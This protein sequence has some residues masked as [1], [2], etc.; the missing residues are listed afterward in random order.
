MSETNITLFDKIN[1]KDPLMKKW[2]A[3]GAAVIVSLIGMMQII[4][5]ALNIGDFGMGYDYIWTEYVMF[6]VQMIGSASS[7]YGVVYV[8]TKQRK[9]IY[10][11]TLGMTLFMI[12]GIVSGMLLEAIKRVF[13]IILNF[14]ILYNWSK[15]DKVPPIKRASNKEWYTFIP[16]VLTIALTFGLII[17]FIDNEAINSGGKYP[18]AA[19]WMDTASFAFSIGGAMF[20]TRTRTESQYG[21]IV[22]DTI[23]MTLFIING[24]W[25]MV[26]T[27][28]VFI[29][30]TFFAISSWTQEG[31]KN[32]KAK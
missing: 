8:I 3:P 13:F 14:V 25:T 30:I 17:H 11:Q 31:I 28:I 7:I 12:N 10:F 16:V 1:K 6:V 9:F 23:L 15:T 4:F 5:F 19:G 32:G 24:Q 18:V 22:S 26:F 21:F 27:Q 29:T 20:A 2:F